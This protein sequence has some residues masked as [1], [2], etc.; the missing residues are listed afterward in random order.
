METATGGSIIFVSFSRAINNS[1]KDL[2]DFLQNKRGADTGSSSTSSVHSLSLIGTVLH[3]R[4]LMYPHTPPLRD[5]P[6]IAVI[7]VRS[8]I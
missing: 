1:H 2:W 4:L 3:Q 8:F 5:S 7:C 6:L